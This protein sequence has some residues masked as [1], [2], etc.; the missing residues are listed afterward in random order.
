MRHFKKLAHFW[1]YVYKMSCQSILVILK[2]QIVMSPALK[3]VG[4][5]LLARLLSS[6]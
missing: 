2:Q 6:S 1:L 5:S 4:E 3:N